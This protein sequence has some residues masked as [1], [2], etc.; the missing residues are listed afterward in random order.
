[1]LSKNELMTYICNEICKSDSI[2]YRKQE[3]KPDYDERFKT[4]EDYNKE[5]MTKYVFDD[6]KKAVIAKRGDC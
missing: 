3:R 2:T 5:I 4:R 1:M 6:I